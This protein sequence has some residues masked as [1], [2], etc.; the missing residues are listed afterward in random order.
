MDKPKDLLPPV[1]GDISLTDPSPIAGNGLLERRLFLQQGFALSVATLGSA[2]AVAET[3]SLEPSRNHPGR[4]FSN[5]GAPL[6][7]EKG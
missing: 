6:S 5:Y 2:D 3:P 4:G 7:H 1:V